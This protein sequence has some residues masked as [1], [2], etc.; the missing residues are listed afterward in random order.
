MKEVERIVLAY[1]KYLAAYAQALLD[2]FQKGAETLKH[3]TERLALLE[4][5]NR[6]R[7]KYGTGHREVTRS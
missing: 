7:R 6:I 1:E 3:E 2:I 5:V 4:K